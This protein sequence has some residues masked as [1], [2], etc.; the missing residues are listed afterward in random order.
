MRYLV[1]Y[2]K[3]PASY[4]AYLPDLPGCVAVGASLAEVRT[5]IHEAVALHLADM[6]ATGQTIPQ[7]SAIE[8]DYVEA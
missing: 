3:G 2:E 4:G 8:M 1:V 6:R 5:L 7:P